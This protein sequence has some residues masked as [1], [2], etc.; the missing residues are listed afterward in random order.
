MWDFCPLFVIFL[1]LYYRWIWN[2]DLSTLAR[3]GLAFTILALMPLVIIIWT[4]IAFVF[5]IS[6]LITKPY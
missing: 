3:L 4:I 6:S 1:G 5:V 2:L